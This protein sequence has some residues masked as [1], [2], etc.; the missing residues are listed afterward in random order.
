MAWLTQHGDAPFFVWIHFAEPHAPHVAP[1][2][3]ELPPGT[4]VE[5]PAVADRI[6]GIDLEKL[7]ATIRAYRAEV[8]YV[9]AQLGRIVERLRLLGR[10]DATALIVTAG[11]GEG[12]G[13]RGRVGHADALYEELVRV[14]LVVRGPGISAG[15]RLLGPAQLEDVAPTIQAWAGVPIPTKSDGFDLLPWFE[16]RAEKSPRAV[17]VGQRRESAN[18]DTLYY[19]LRG[20]EKW[21][22]TAG[23]PGRRFD[24]GSDPEERA[25]A[26]GSGMPE[27]LRSAIEKPAET[28]PAP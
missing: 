4:A 18:G 16:G 10:L 12:L 28:P 14:P 19:Q 3:F 6:A 23:S 27:E 11:Q 13:E 17:V 9:D 2:G 24:H 8:A 5:R 20:K 22:G 21:I 7:D 1:R 26:T 15:R 25:P